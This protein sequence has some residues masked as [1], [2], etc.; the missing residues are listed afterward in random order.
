MEEK[1]EEVEEEE[2]E[3]EDVIQVGSKSLKFHHTL[4]MMDGK[5]KNAITDTKSSLHCFLCGAS[6]IHFNEI[7]NLAKDFLTKEENLAFGGSA[8]STHGFELSTP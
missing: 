7:A 4:Q 5:V 6:S 8:I 2:E 3:E 1:E